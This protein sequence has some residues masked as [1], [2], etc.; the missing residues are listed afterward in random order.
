MSTQVDEL[1]HRIDGPEDAPVVVLGSS[2]GT[3]LGMWDEQARELSHRYRVLRFDTR[4]HGESPVGDAT[5]SLELLA[6]DVVHLVDSLGIERFAYVGLSLG[7]GIGQQLALDHAP[8]LTAL[9]LCCTAP[10]FG[11]PATWRERA[12]RVRAEGMG[13]LVEPTKERWFPPGYVEEHPERAGLLL[14]MLAGAPP[15]GYAA[16]CDA[17]AEFDVTAR[18]GE[19][20][21]PTRVIAGRHDP[22]TTPEVC[23]EL[24]AAVADGDLVVVEGASHIANIATPEKFN[25]AVLEHLRRHSDGARQQR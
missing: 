11:D 19:I 4:G 20:D 23:A 8:R 18:L 22:V 15:A 7:G 5:I 21:V 6:E 3:T 17:L 13:W 16:C 24:A 1:N 14:D 2:L 9:V 12:A 10:R 25:V